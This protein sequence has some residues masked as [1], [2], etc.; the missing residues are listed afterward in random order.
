[1]ARNKHRVLF[2]CLGNICRSPLAEGVFRREVERRGLSHE[3]LIDSA[4]TSSWHVGE[5]P[6]ER[7]QAVARRNGVDISMQRSRKL[8][9]SD[10]LEFDWI[11]AMD[12]SN[13]DA[14]RRR[15][16][17]GTTARVVEFVDYVPGDPPHEVPD[18]YYGGPGGFDTVFALLERG[19]GPL[20]DAVL[21]DGS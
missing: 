14:A 2:L 11:V 15:K 7:G 6:D 17:G 8:R 4:G 5:A 3:L 12:P 16:P 13:A 9:E 21:A 20:L 18:P 1:M 19:A 10:F